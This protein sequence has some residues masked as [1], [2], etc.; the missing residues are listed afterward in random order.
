[1]LSLFWGGGFGGGWMRW[2]GG[3][4]GDNNLVNARVML[5]A[6]KQLC[7]APLWGVG[8][9]DNNLPMLS[10]TIFRVTLRPFLCP[11][12]LKHALDA[13]LLTFYFNLITLLMVRSE[14]FVLYFYTLLAFCQLNW[15]NTLLMVRCQPSCAPEVIFHTLVM[16]H[17]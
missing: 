8:W 2:V 9:G 12:K 17:S 3:G 6:C 14:P 5:R 10:F 4:V 13:A 1:M 7:N 15:L 16:L 11:I